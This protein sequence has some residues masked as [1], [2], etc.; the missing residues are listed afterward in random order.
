[1]SSDLSNSKT[2][3]PLK[4][5]LAFELLGAEEAGVRF[6]VHNELVA[7]SQMT[8]QLEPAAQRGLV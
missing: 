6:V 8:Q 1:M 7:I 2:G 4:L 3:V 5:G